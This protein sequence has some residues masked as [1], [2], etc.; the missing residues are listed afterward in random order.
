MLFLCLAL[1]FFANATR[2][3]TLK[4][5][6]S[7]FACEE[8]PDN[9]EFVYLKVKVKSKV[10]KKGIFKFKGVK[11]L[12]LLFFLEK[13]QKKRGGV[14][15]SS[16]AAL[17]REQTFENCLS[18]PSIASLRLLSPTRLHRAGTLKGISIP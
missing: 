5:S 6:S 12:I 8:L 4:A 3:H 2:A 18:A 13:K 7:G 15:A 17:N 1:P 9:R 10:F 11:G 16:Q 14:P